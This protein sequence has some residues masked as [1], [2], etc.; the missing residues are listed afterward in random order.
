[1]CKQYKIPIYSLLTG[2][3]ITLITGFFP[4]VFLGKYSYSG[5]FLPWSKKI[6]YPGA[7][8]EISWIYFIVDIVIWSVFIYLALLSVGEEK[9]EK[10]VRK[11]PQRKSP[12]RKR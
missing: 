6:I 1:M 7:P 11:R 2:I 3:I 10:T 8:L 4:N 12:Q 5:Y 9:K